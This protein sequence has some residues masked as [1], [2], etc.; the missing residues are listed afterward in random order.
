MAETDQYAIHADFAHLAKFPTGIS[1]WRLRVVNLIIKAQRAAARTSGWKPS[2]QHQ[3]LSI[4]GVAQNQIPLQVFRPEGLPAKAPV[5]VYCHGGGF[6]CTYV[7]RHLELLDCYAREAKCVVVM[8]E[9]RLTPAHPFPAGFDDC[10]ATL[11]WV[12][13]NA[14]SLGIDR[15]AL[16]IGGDSAGG[17]LAASV[18]QKALKESD[19]AL[20][21]QLL[22]YPVI[23][24]DCKTPSA[25]GYERV[26]MWTAITNRRM[27]DYYL[28]GGTDKAPPY[29]SPYHG[30]LAGLPQAYIE[31]AEFDP[32]HDEGLNY[33]QKL[34]A[35]GVTV[36]VNET[37]GT[38]HGYD[39]VGES[40]ITQEALSKRVDFLKEIFSSTL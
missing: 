3:R 10:Y 25:S 8:M 4:P 7:Q 31:T 5:L 13:D 21:G 27:W 1:M 40:E 26:P 36:T 39:A 30:D 34:Q 28:P 24:K 14:D 35:Q 29:A 37:L 23:D 22:I 19:I 38:V 11:R 16:A 33:A 32:L 6:A 15:S 9:Y 2:C 17:A 18:A 12:Y 20:C